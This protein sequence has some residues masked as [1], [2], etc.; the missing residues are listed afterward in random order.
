MKLP[1]SIDGT[2][3]YE[4]DD[5]TPRVAPLCP[6]AQEDPEPCDCGHE[7]EWEHRWVYVWHKPKRTRGS[8]GAAAKANGWKVIAGFDERCPGCH[9][10]ERFD[11]NAELLGHERGRL[12]EVVRLLPTGA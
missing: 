5:W 9:D 6:K 7:G 10:V 3:V 2:P 4:V 8:Y 12:A 1:D 11:L